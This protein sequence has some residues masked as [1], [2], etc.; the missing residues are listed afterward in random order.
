LAPSASAAQK[1][2]SRAQLLPTNTL[3]SIAAPEIE[4]L[5]PYPREDRLFSQIIQKTKLKPLFFVSTDTVIVG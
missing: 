5:V 4:I 2:R 3:F 1:P